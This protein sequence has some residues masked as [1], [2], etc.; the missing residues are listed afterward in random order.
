[1]QGYDLQLS[2]DGIF[3]SYSYDTR[4]EGTGITALLQAINVANG[5]VLK[6]IKTSQ[7]SLEDIFIDI[8]K[9]DA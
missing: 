1:L 5:V 2:D 7:S 6:D 9:E 4:G 3:L 8:L